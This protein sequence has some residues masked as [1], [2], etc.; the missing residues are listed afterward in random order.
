MTTGADDLNDDAIAIIAL[1]GRFPGAPTVEAFWENLSQGVESIRV[2]A[3]EELAGAGVPEEEFRSPDYVPAKAVLDDIAGFDA[4]YFGVS[5][6]EAALIDPQQRLFLE[7]CVELLE[8]AA[9]GPGRG[10]ERVSVY[11]GVSKNTYL[12][13]NLLSHPELR[14]SPGALQTLGANDKDYLATRVSHKLGLRGPSITVQTACSSSLTAVHIAC[15]SLL[16]GESDY[17]VAGGVALDVPHL[18]GYTYEPG[19][20]FSPDG[21]CRA[22]DA[23]ARG[24]VFGQGAGAVLLRRLPD[25]LAAG[26]RIHAVIRGSAVNN[27]GDAKAGFTAPSVEGQAAVVVEALANAGVDAETISYVEAHGTGTALGDPIEV[28]AL[29]RAYRLWTDRTGFCRIGSVKTNIGHLNAASGIAGLI[30]T[31]LALRHELI[32]ASLHYRRPNSRI[33]FAET[34]FAVAAEPVPWPEN[35]QTPRRAGVSSFGI[36]GTN[37]HVVLESAPEPQRAPAGRPWQL[38]PLSARSPAA[39]GRLAA[40][41]GAALAAGGELDLADVGYTHQTGR[42]RF[43]HRAAVTA[44]DTAHAA[45]LLAAPVTRPAG[46][47]RATVVLLF[48]GQGVQYPGL[49]RGLY[50]QEPVFRQEM[51]E[52]AEILRDL[53]GADPLGFLEPSADPVALLRTEAAQPVL[54][55]V[56]HALARLWESW[57]VRPEAVAGHSLGEITAVCAAGVLDRDDALRLVAER[58]RLMGE[59]PAGAMLAAACDAGRLP[60]PL[61]DGVALA[62]VNSPVQTV[63]SGP[64]APIELVRETLAEQEIRCRRLPGNNAF[65]SPLMAEAAERL[66][67][68]AAGLR[69]RAPRLPVISNVTGRWMRDEEATDPRYWGR[70]LLSSVRFMAGAGELLAAERV[71][72]ETGPGQTLSRLIRQHPSWSAEAHRAVA[73]LPGRPDSGTADRQAMLEAAGALWECGTEPEWS[74]LLGGPR[75][76]V[77]LPTYPFERT[78]HWIDPLPLGPG[79]PVATLPQPS[80]AVSTADDL[81]PADADD[82]QER[83][84]TVFETL[85]GVDGVRADDDFFDLG[86]HSLLGV[87]LVTRLRDAT[88]VRLPLTA[89]FDRPHPAGIVALLR[90]ARSEGLSAA[91]AGVGVDSREDIRLEPD[92]RLPASRAAGHTDPGTVLLTG[93]SGFLGNFLLREL[94]QQTSATVEC[95][96]RAPDPAAGLARLTAGLHRYGL[97]EDA[98]LSR[99]RVLPGD[100]AQD[101]LGLPAAEYDR[102]ARTVDVIYHNGAKVSFLEPYP[103]IRKTNVKGVHEILRLAG[104][105]RLKTVHHVSTIAVFDCDALADVTIAAEDTDLSRGGGFHGGYDE[106]K[107]VAERI[108]GLAREAGFPVTVFRP[109]NIAG[110]SRT[111]VVSDGHRVEAAVEHE[112]IYPVTVTDQ[113]ETGFAIE[114]AGRVL[115]ADRVVELPHPVTAS[116]DFA[117]VLDQVPGAFVFLGACPPGVNPGETPV[118]HSADAVFDEAVL[119]DAARLLAELARWRLAQEADG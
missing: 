94:L 100:F 80:A 107:W 116:E 33:P 69:L 43:A 103:L 85:L 75:R 39:L 91:L 54:F 45:E 104:E 57:G 98:D 83:V 68:F 76:P 90:T 21:H 14:R 115:G 82:L 4:G 5:P 49:A 101:G 118:N 41:L 108:L 86:G 31:V 112:A 30:K 79:D 15:Q 40:D 64:E 2:F 12:F 102:L 58:A 27:D 44:R 87:E 60:S 28:E 20:I 113:R 34:P 7:I 19:G 66:T 11:A 47:M 89:I 38:V 111:G 56:E 67:A 9:L 35:G 51:D 3:A 13:F 52:C 48:P 114:V 95:L 36:G 78:R 16:S 119:P 77:V 24:T 10:R 105:H 50:A 110:H 70:Q 25:A 8:R 29:T 63:L 93:A 92:L 99:V 61:P 96:V 65:H 46:P 59:A 6:R 18:A 71:F 97:L 22:F 73:C 81:R 37:V 74:R 32:P 106:S 53:G 109:G 26:D 17:A 117:F 23:D 84:I 88:G 55:T 1:A 62:A 72:L 42:R